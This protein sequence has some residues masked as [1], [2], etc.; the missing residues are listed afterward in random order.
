MKKINQCIVCGSNE[1]KIIFK[2][3][4][5]KKE[6]TPLQYACTC[7][8][9][10]KHFPIVKCKKCGL[11]YSLYR[12]KDN[13]ISDVY[14]MVEDF[15]YL[16]EEKG[17]NLTYLRNINSIKKYIG[18]GDL[19]DV[20]SYC[21]FFLKT[22]DDNGFKVIG[23]E[24]SL[25]AAEYAKKRFGSKVVSGEIKNTDFQQNYFDVVTMWDVI[26][27]LT[28]PENDLLKIK[29][30]IKKDGLLILSSYNIES[31]TAKIL[32]TNYPFLMRMHLYH[33]SP[34][35]ISLLLTKCGFK[36][37]KIEPHIR[38]V[39]LSYFLTRFYKLQNKFNFIIKK[40]EKSKLGDV[41]LYFYG[42]GIMNV[43]AKKE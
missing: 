43:Y 17:R 7:N 18:Y 5:K 28:N 11:V 10:G 40:I 24:P 38:V 3:T 31:L 16:K 36:V 39:R 12:D 20:G 1:F 27:H 41:S 8:A 35:T 23:L 6:I 13:E 22:A 26:E 25:W 29:Q 21:G 34:K 30:W 14:K 15:Q 33:F 37:I 9:L 2:S 42:L 4:I 32:G 19:L